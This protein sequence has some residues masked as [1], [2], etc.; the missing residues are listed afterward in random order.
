MGLGRALPE[1]ARK[2]ILHPHPTQFPETAKPA[3]DALCSPPRSL[4]SPVVAHCAFPA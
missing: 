4:G 2:G 1:E 3:R